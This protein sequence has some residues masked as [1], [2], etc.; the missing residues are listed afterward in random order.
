MLYNLQNTDEIKK[1]DERCVWL[2]SKGKTVDL[3]EKKNTRTTNQ[4]SALHML[5]GIMTNQLNEL[6]LEFHYFGLKG[7]VLTTRYTPFI[8]KEHLWRPIQITMFGIT[9]T[10]KINTEQINEIV[11]VLSKWFG[12]KGVVIQF[13]SKETIEKMII[14][15]TSV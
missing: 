14:K 15:R 10:T 1:F 9:S 4:N 2:K 11:D 5:F 6:G 13:P 3:I 7:Q 8:C 12:E